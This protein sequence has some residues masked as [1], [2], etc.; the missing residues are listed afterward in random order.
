MP[1]ANL[2]SNLTT[3]APAAL[4]Y[5]PSSILAGTTSHQEYDTN[6]DQCQK[7]SD[8]TLKCVVLLGDKGHSTV[9]TKS[10]APDDKAAKSE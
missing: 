8:V 3:L 4:T 10:R 5:D 2:T 1:H 7:E 9:G 6:D